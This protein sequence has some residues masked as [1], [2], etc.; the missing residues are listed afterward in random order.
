M[1]KNF[2]IYPSNKGLISRIY[3]EH[4][5]TRKNPIKRMELSDASLD[6]SERLY[7]FHLSVLSIQFGRQTQANHLRLGVQEQLGQHSGTP[8]LLKIQKSA[9][10]DS[11]KSPLIIGSLL[12][13]QGRMK[14][15]SDK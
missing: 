14:I 10:R 1:G 13:S 8:S 15:L 4:K 9:G 3:K 7:F 11:H 12:Q 6:N 5:F 2:A